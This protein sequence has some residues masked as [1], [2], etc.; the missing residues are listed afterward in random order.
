MGDWSCM[1]TPRFGMSGKEKVFEVWRAMVRNNKT[2]DGDGASITVAEVIKFW[3]KGESGNNAMGGCSPI[4]SV[5][6]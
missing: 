2:V 1:W 4:I 6:P 5:V 3:L